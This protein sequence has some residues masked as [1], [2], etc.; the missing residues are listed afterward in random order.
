M[1]SPD[2][3]S[4]CRCLEPAL[5]QGHAMPFRKQLP[6]CY[7]ALMELEHLNVGYQVNM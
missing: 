3:T 4:Q 6:A 2:R 7:W 1:A 5:E